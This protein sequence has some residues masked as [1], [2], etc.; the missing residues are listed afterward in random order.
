MPPRGST[1]VLSTY[2]FLQCDYQTTLSKFMILRRWTLCILETELNFTLFARV[3]TTFFFCLTNCREIKL[4]H[5]HNPVLLSSVKV[6]NQSGS[7]PTATTLQ[8]QRGTGWGLGYQSKHTKHVTDIPSLNNYINQNTDD[9]VKFHMDQL[10]TVVQ[11]SVQYLENKFK[12]KHSKGQ[13]LSP[14]IQLKPAEF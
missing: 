5:K 3:L 13:K 7:R 8:P 4:R 10:C 11:Y 14:L 2:S 9:T 12:M 1:L 6:A